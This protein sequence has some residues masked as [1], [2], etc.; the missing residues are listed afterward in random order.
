MI[1]DDLPIVRADSEFD[2]NIKHFQS[3]DHIKKLLQN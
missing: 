2:R 1:N 3:I